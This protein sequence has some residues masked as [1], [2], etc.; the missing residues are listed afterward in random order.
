MRWK[1]SSNNEPLTCELYTIT[2]IWKLMLKYAL[3]NLCVSLSLCIFHFFSCIM[4]VQQLT[5]LLLIFHNIIWTKIRELSRYWDQLWK[6]R[7]KVA[8]ALVLVLVIFIVILVLVLQAIRG[9]I[10]RRTRLSGCTL[11]SLFNFAQSF[12]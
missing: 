11:N 6:S 5:M 10:P 2:N 9:S 3:N 12:S 4:I 1:L 8:S 7:T